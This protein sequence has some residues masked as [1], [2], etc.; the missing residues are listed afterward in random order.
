[1]KSAWRSPSRWWAGKARLLAAAAAGC[2][3][4]SGAFQASAEPLAV[5]FAR[6]YSALETDKLYRGYLEH[7]AQCTG[8]SL[9]NHFGQ[10][11]FGRLYVAETVA[12][13][14]IP[15]LLQGGRLQVAMVPS[16]MAAWLESKGIA[17][18]VAIRGQIG[19]QQAETFEMLLLTRADSPTATLAQLTGA[20]IGFPNARATGAEE[21]GSPPLDDMLAG[22]ALAKAG[23]TAG[24]DYRPEYPGGHERALVGLQSGFWQGA[25]I[26]SDQFDRMVKK[27]EAKVRDFR[28][29]WRSPPLPTESVVVAKALPAASKAKIAKC[30]QAHRFTAEQSRLFEGSD[31]FLPVSPALYEPYRQLLR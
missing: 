15:A 18:P 14:Q 30:T 19:S 28:V 29:V 9:T 2:M 16:A 10:S 31:G 24:K 3:A 1:M 4:L 27:R 22:A 23:L 11:L 12:E 20:K 13:A 8:A 6:T 5:A 17:E 21:A 25:F 26:G 7:L